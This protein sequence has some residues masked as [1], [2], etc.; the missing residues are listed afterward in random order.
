MFC[1]IS[2]H[3]GVRNLYQIPHNTGFEPTGTFSRNPTRIRHCLSLTRCDKSKY[4]GF[5]R[6]PT[7]VPPLRTGQSQNRIFASAEPGPMFGIEVS[8][9]TNQI[10]AK[11][12]PGAL[13]GPSPSLPITP[14][15]GSQGGNASGSPGRRLRPRFLEIGGKVNVTNRGI[16]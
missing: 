2:T 14:G 8:V 16:D 12:I 13:A 6:P 4:H 7:G 15:S 11:T 1:R 9:Q 10:L 3:R 5:E